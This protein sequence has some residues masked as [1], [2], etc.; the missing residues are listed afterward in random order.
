MIGAAYAIALNTFREAVRDRIR[1]HYHDPPELD[2]PTYKTLIG[3]TRKYAVPLM[4]LFDDERLTMRRG[5]VRLLRAR[6]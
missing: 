3:T 4:E 5:A 2:T 1:A 6:R